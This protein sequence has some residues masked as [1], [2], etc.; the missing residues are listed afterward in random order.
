MLKG[1]KVTLRAT[2]REDVKRLWELDRDNVDLVILGDSIWQP[3]PLAAFEKWYDKHIENP[4]HT[5]FVI[6]ADGKIIGDINLHGLD[7]PHSTAELGIG[8]YDRDYLGKGYGRD[9]INVLLRW[10]FRVHNWR[11]I[12]LETVAINERAIRAYKACGFVE[13]GRLREQSFHNG[14]Y[15]DVVLMG[16]L[17]HEWEAQQSSTHK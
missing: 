15:V 13:E 9:A 5:W 4:E 1:E 12:W 10:A 16:L 14:Q 3:R 17:R 2:E 8:I 11:K 6:E 7:R